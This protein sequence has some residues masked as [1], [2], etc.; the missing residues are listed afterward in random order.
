LCLR[1]S[2]PCWE[3]SLYHP[4]MAT[5]PLPV[6]AEASAVHAAATPIDLHADTTKFMARGYDFYKRPR[7]PW[8]LRNYAG[9]VDLP[10][11]REGNLRGQ[12]FGMWTFPKPESG[13]VAEIHRQID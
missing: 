10:R 9:H 2:I 3:V 7:P 4:A 11:M 6:S 5:S 1:N 12:F 8:P 13:S